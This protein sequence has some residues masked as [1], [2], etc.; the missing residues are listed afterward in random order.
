MIRDPV[1]RVYSVV[2]YRLLLGDYRIN[3]I[4]K[5]V[6]SFKQ[7]PWLN[8]SGPGLE[9]LE[10]RAYL[11]RHGIPVEEWGRGSAKGIEHL[12]EELGSGECRL[13]S[14]RGVLYR[15][16]EFVMCWIL[17]VSPEGVWRLVES[18]QVFKDGRVR[19]REKDSSVSEKMRPGEDPF[20]CLVRGVEEELGIRLAPDQ[21]EALSFLQEERESGSFP[22]LATRYRGHRFRC[23]LDRSQWR[24]TGYLERQPDKTTHF[25]WVLEEPLGTP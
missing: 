23:Y 1:S 10:L 7:L 13:V 17:Y 8:E 19:V 5:H 25:S 9:L 21:V 11:L 16:I 3:S 18:K 22:G 4:M 15:E 12:A 24:P 20:L 6:K 14:E 2:Q